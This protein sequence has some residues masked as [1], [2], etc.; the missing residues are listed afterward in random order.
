MSVD[1]SIRA[2]IIAGFS[3]SEMCRN[4]Y[5]NASFHL[6]FQPMKSMKRKDTEHNVLP[7]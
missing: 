7:Y 6:L 1:S 3:Q 5:A 2:W 4:E